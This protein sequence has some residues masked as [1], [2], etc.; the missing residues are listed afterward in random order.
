MHRLKSPSEGMLLSE[1]TR[2]MLFKITSM[3]LRSGEYISWFR[4]FSVTF[5]CIGSIVPWVSAVEENCALKL[6]EWRRATAR[7]VVL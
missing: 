7:D 1:M 5:R 2:L 6:A 4:M 3:G